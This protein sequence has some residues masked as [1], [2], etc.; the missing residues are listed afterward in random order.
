MKAAHPL[1]HSLGM[2]LYSTDSPG[3]G[4]RLKERFEDFIVQEITSDQEILSLEEW[5]EKP[6]TQSIDGERSRF[7]TFTVQ[8]MGLATMDVATILASS[9]KISRNY[10]TY[11]GLKDKRAVTV[12]SMSVP[13]RTAEMLATLDLSRIA[14]R[15]IR[16]TRQPIQIG[17]LWGNRFS[18]HLKDITVDSETA[19]ALTKELSRTSLLNYFGVQRFGL[20]RPYTHLV[21]RALV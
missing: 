5:P 2:E 13:A 14:I 18:I 21:G 1:E 12:Q 20:T 3:I 8:K 9:L 4:G 16:Y 15:D 6:I 10:V 7:L 17:D 11:A 19:L